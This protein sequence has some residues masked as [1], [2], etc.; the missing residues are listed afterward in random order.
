[1]TKLEHL[2]SAAWYSGKPF[3]LFDGMGMRTLPPS[4]LHE[5]M[6][7]NRVHAALRDIMCAMF[8]IDSRDIGMAGGFYGS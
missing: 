3:I 5:Q 8:P 2:N 6:Q 4:L 1:M 7:M